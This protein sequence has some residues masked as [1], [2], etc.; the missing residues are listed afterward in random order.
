MVD[1]MMNV[2]MDGWFDGWMHA[3]KIIDGLML[4]G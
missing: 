2:I 1:E 4:V 3:E